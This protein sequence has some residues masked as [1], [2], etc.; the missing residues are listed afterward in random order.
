MSPAMP[1][2]KFCGMPS[3]RCDR[4]RRAGCLGFSRP[5]AALV[6]HYRI[7]IIASRLVPQGSR[8]EWLANRTF[9]RVTI[10]ASEVGG[11]PICAF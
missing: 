10:P 11:S 7:H 5:E 8:S 4:R 6:S 2:S 9:E 1:S 3:A